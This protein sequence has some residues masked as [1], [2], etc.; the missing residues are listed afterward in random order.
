MVE[1]P[2]RESPKLPKAMRIG[3]LLFTVG[4]LATLA[5]A[6]AL[7]LSSVRQ[8]IFAADRAEIPHALELT[9]KGGEYTLLLLPNPL[10]QTPYLGNVEAYLRCDVLRPD[11]TTETIDCSRQAIGGETDAG[12]ELGHFVTTA[13][14]TRVTCHFENNRPSSGYYYSAAA[15]SL[16][17]R[18]AALTLLIG[19]LV[20]L[21]GGIL[22][23]TLGYR[24]RAAPG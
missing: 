9:G 5:G 4:L 24:R 12:T 6:L 18:G 19:G 15:T 16:W 8:A 20:A 17:Y 2:W 7:W 1:T 22:L 3:G 11:A 10:P 13:G 23:L 14:T 21:C